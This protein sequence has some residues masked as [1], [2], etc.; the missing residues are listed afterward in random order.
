MRNLR[1]VGL[2]TVLAITILIGGYALWSALR[3]PG[4]SA[5]GAPAWSAAPEE[6]LK[7]GRFDSLT[8]YAPSSPPRG[9]VLLL[10]GAEG[11]SGGMAAMAREL[12]RRGAM[13]AGIDSRQLLANLEADDSDC[14]FPDGDLEN[15]SHFVQAYYRLPAYLPPILAGD[16]AGAALAYAA[17]A[18]APPDTFAGAVSADFC[19]QL[20]SRKAWCKSAGLDYSPRPHGEGFELLPAKKLVNPW[21]VIAGPAPQEC[22]S[23]A[24]ARFAAQVANAKVA[25]GSGGGPGPP[26]AA[27]A[28]ENAVEMLMRSSAPPAQSMIPAQL[29]DLPIVVVA[30]P[31][32]SA[33]SH[34]LA[35]MLSGDG[36][37]AGLD[38]DVAGAL[39]AQGITVIGLDSLRYFWSPRTPEGL[40]GDLDRIVRH[41]VAQFGRQRVLLIGYSQGADV[42]P[43]AVNRLSPDTRKRVILTAVMGMSEHALFEFHLSSWIS[44]DE[45][46]PATLPEVDRISGSSVLCIYGSDEEDSLCPKLDP[47][48][49]AIVKLQGGHHFDG[50]YG[51]LARAILSAV[52]P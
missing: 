6:K 30:A 12:A 11:W 49:V 48:R 26:A 33:A 43:F 29:G 39:A 31:P 44:N 50:D 42:L 28:F 36:G 46:G 16:A 25:D 47:H 8:V 7:H 51:A 19:P 35:I 40:A 20:K 14:V 4:R 9:F 34:L 32:G 27:A 5:G 3:P 1:A 52:R 45:S 2:L 37:W 23:P 15:L 24:A 10:S 22:A 18:Q 21:V 38:K 13:V 17:L 41:G